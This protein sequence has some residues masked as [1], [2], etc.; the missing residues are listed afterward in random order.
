VEYGERAV[1]GG[2]DPVQ[3]VREFNEGRE[4]ANIMIGHIQNPEHFVALLLAEDGTEVEPLTYS[5]GYYTGA[6]LIE[7]RVHTVSD[8]GQKPWGRGEQSTHPM[9]VAASAWAANYGVTPTTMP[10]AKLCCPLLSV[11]VALK[12]A[13]PAVFTKTNEHHEFDQVDKTAMAVIDGTNIRCAH[14]H[15][16]FTDRFNMYMQGKKTAQDLINQDL[17]AINLT[18]RRTGEG[19]VTTGAAWRT[20]IKSSLSTALGAMAAFKAQDAVKY[21]KEAA[22]RAAYSKDKL[23]GKDPSTAMTTTVTTSPTK[24]KQTARRGSR[25]TGLG[26]TEESK[27]K[28]AATRARN[29]AAKALAAAASETQMTVRS[30]S[31]PPS[32]T[33]TRRSRSS[34]SQGRRPSHRLPARSRSPSARPVMARSPSARPRSP[35]ARPRS[36]S[37]RPRSPSARSRSPS[38]RLSTPNTHR[39]SRSEGDR[40]HASS[41]Q[42]RPRR[43]GADY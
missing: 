15:T 4:P 11:F 28:A 8:R 3:E 35:S 10:D 19:V 6:F 32:S 20:F 18:T 40:G 29:K 23:A 39:R 12:T 25:G 13:F 21:N 9:D 14:T 7:G 41:R 31:L 37:A 16:C 27:R 17:D 33:P 1:Y 5:K 42:Q 22:N 38:A 34:S 2:R 30:S 36:P 24:R 43:A 26:Y